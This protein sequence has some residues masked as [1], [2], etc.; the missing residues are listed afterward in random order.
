MDRLEKSQRPSISFKKG[1][2]SLRLHFL[3][4]LSTRNSIITRQGLQDC[5]MY[6]LQHIWKV[7]SCVKRKDDADPSLFTKKEKQCMA[8]FLT[9]QNEMTLSFQEDK[10]A[11]PCKNTNMH[12]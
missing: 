12:Y 3:L 9:Q 10:L 7:W 6:S 8:N 11:W 4:L 5:C 1:R 2:K